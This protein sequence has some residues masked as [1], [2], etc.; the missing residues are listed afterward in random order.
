MFGILFLSMEF[1]VYDLIFSKM[2]FCFGEKAG[3][4][5]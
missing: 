2:C 5:T 1:D 3:V 4:R